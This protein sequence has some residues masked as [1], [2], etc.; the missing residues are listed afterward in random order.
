[1]RR[2]RVELS[3]KD[4]KR[5]VDC[6][7]VDEDHRRAENRG[8]QDPYGIHRVAVPFGLAGSYPRG[9]NQDA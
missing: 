3:L 7:A 1:L 9:M 8:H 5:N 2:R 6:G 4:G